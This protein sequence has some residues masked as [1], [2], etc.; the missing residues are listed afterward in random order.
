MIRLFHYETYVSEMNFL[1]NGD[2]IFLRFPV[3]RSPTDSQMHGCL[4]NVASA[5]VYSG[6]DGFLFRLPQRP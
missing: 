6:F 2:L 4:K 5:F 1:G 3:E